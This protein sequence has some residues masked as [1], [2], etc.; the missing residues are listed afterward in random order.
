MAYSKRVITTGYILT[1]SFFFSSVFKQD[2]GF[3]KKVGVGN[4]YFAEFHLPVCIYRAIPKI[5]HYYE[6]L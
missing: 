6:T 3:P 2:Y 5:R 1:S 4:M